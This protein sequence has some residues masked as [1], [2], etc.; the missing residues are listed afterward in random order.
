[1][2]T[3]VSDKYGFGTYENLNEIIEQVRDLDYGELYETTL[4]CDCGEIIDGLMDENNEV[5]AV[6]TEHVHHSAW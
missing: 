6:E 2:F 4:W 5:V 1:M 3:I